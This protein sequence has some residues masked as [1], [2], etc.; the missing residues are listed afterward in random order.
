M[1]FPQRKRSIWACDALPFILGVSF[2]W[3]S[4]Q[5][6]FISSYI[7]KNFSNYEGTPPS[8]SPYTECTLRSLNM[9]RGKKA[10]R[11]FYIL[12]NCIFQEWKLLNF[13][14][15]F[16]NFFNLYHY[17]Q[18]YTGKSEVTWQLCSPIYWHVENRQE[19]FAHLKKNCFVFR[20]QN[21][22]SIGKYRCT[23]SVERSYS[24]GPGGGGQKQVLHGAPKC[25]ARANPASLQ[26]CIFALTPR[27]LN[28]WPPQYFT[29]SDAPVCRGP[30]LKV[31]QT[32]H[33]KSGKSTLNL[34]ST[35]KYRELQ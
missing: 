16:Q 3:K 10:K 19:Y 14:L 22:C 29:P 9:Q 34:H 25:M 33:T 2:T 27:N 4:A 15:K 30:V 6:C 7:W 11:W 28:L 18:Q 5:N 35:C 32:L 23:L 1:L 20:R 12:Q 8:D 13:E 17:W 21:S 31:R 24:N 26:G